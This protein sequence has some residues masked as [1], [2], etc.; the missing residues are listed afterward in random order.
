MILLVG[1]VLGI[2]IYHMRAPASASA[3]PDTTSMAPTEKKIVAISPD[4]AKSTEGGT[5]AGAGGPTAAQS[6]AL[7]GQRVVHFK[8]ASDLQTFLND[9]HK[10]GLTV[11]GVIPAL[12]MVR[13]GAA[14]EGVLDKAL[15]G[16]NAADIGQNYLVSIPNDPSTTNA[17]SQNPLVPFGQNW[18]SAMG[19]TSPDPTW[20][21]GVKVAVVD[22]GIDPN[23]TFA[24]RTIP[25]IDLTNDSTSTTGSTLSHGTAVASL[26]AGQDS[27]VPGIAPASS[28]LSIKVLDANGEGDTFTVAQGVIRAVEEGS[29]II[30]L[31][32]GSSGDSTVLQEAI[33]YAQARGV[34]VVAASGNEGA[35]QLDYPA[36]YPGVLAVGA[37]DGTLQPA[38]FSN[39][40]TGLGVVAPGVGLPAG[41]GTDQAVSFSGTSAAAPTVSGALAAILSSDHTVTPIQAMNLILAYADDMGPPG[42]DSSTGYGT[43]DLGRVLARNTPNIYDG[44]V[45]AQFV[46]GPVLAGQ[47]V[48]VGI[49]VQNRGTAPILSGTLTTQALGNSSYFPIQNL[50]PGQSVMQVIQIY[51]S[52]LTN[53]Q[54]TVSSQLSLNGVTDNNTSNNQM[55]SR[56][57]V[58]AATGH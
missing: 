37:I 29:Q 14:S 35:D 41:W 42:W 38:S 24:G 33:A 49:T 27:Q 39:S 45:A 30:N 15:E 32:L 56:L 57:K 2:A 10:R 31:S 4:T 50:A 26:I 28:L 21:Q 36:K 47:P 13:V 48:S 3:T 44:A 54:T 23:V 53:G 22:M 46:N 51:P 6:K 17:S 12:K 9:A 7:P 1:G 11:L 5:L 55:T 16:T 52:T 34:A 40:G 43:V 18:M 20:G 25:S 8:S 58:T 19:V